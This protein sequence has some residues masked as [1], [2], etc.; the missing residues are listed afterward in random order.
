MPTIVLFVK[1]VVPPFDIPPPDP[2]DA[3]HKVALVP[4][5]KLP[6]PA[7]LPA[8]VL[9]TTFT[10]PGLILEI[11]PPEAPIENAVPPPPPGP[12]GVRVSPFEAE[13]PEKV[14][15]VIFMVPPLLRIPPPDAPP[16]NA[17]LRLLTVVDAV[18]P[19]A[20]LFNTVQ[21]IKFTVP[22]VWL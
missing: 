15:L 6:P 22:V 11:P 9:F 17:L 19:R 2:P 20:E 16:P 1:F 14:L 8:N 3:I 18:P 10:M 21:F 12:G 13:L 4:N 5:M 7:E